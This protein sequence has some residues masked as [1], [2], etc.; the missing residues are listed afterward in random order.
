MTRI[1]GTS[2]ASAAFDS[3][4]TA[5]PKPALAA[6]AID[7]APWAC[8]QLRIA[9]NCTQRRGSLRWRRQARSG[10]ALALAVRRSGCW[11]CRPGMGRRRTIVDACCALQSG[12]WTGLR[13]CSAIIRTGQTCTS[14]R[15]LLRSCWHPCYLADWSF[16]VSSSLPY[17]ALPALPAPDVR[18]S[19]A[20]MPVP[21]RMARPSSIQLLG[22]AEKATTCG[23]LLRA[24][25]QAS[26]WRSQT[27]QG[28]G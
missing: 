28:R 27:V 19:A 5:R 4:T 3:G 23:V 1:A 9:R 17:R 24:K 11:S 12:F 13:C 10:A 21:P 16:P 26:V 20:H 7:A 18:P 8:T 14:S 6:A 2:A 15:A 22:G 25:Q